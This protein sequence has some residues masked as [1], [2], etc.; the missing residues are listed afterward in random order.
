MNA[1]YNNW[2]GQQ[3]LNWGV[4]GVNTGSGRAVGMAA[5]SRDTIPVV[6]VFL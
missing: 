1:F 4:R 6:V 2:K 5:E 3:N